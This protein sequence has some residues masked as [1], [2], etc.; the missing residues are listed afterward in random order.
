[1][2]I[3]SDELILILLFILTVGLMLNITK[4]DIFNALVYLA[5]LFL[6]GGFYYSRKRRKARAQ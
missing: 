4:E 1:M 6:A 2:K 3:S 5:G